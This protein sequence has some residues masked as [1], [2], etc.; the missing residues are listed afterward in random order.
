MVTKK[1]YQV[2]LS[3]PQEE[4]WIEI[5]NDHREAIKEV[6][7]W[8]NDQKSKGG[9]LYSTAEY[10]LEKAHDQ[11]LIAYGKE[12]AAIA[13]QLKIKRGSVLAL[14]FIYEA[15]ACCTSVIA[16][17]DQNGTIH[18]FRTMD[19][20]L[21]VLKKLTIVV[22]FYRDKKRV[23][24]TVTWAGY[25]GIF[26]GMRTAGSESW[27]IAVNFRRTPKTGSLLNNMQNAISGN[28]PIGF[29][30]RNTLASSYTFKEAEKVFSEESLISPTY[31]SISGIN[32]IEGVILVR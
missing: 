13:D 20:D 19:W 31:F 26:T 16:R 24:S 2:D 23:F 21:S 6:F 32:K 8:Y 28:W 30:V 4:R 17:K 12:I 7:I 1:R 11:G 18:H 29:L 3:L 5:I 14:Q 15:S 10:I 27:A 25:V 22:D 9:V